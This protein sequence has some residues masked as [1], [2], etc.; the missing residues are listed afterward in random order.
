M[1]LAELVHA[2]CEAGL[3][4]SDWPKWRGYREMRAATSHTYDEDKAGEV[5]ATV[6]DFLDEARYLLARLD[7]RRTPASGSAP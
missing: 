5:F 6:P 2:G 3:L 1:S 7:A 4:R